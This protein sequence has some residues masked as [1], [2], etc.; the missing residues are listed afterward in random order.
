MWTNVL[1][2]I[3]IHSTLGHLWLYFK[4]LKKEMRNP[5]VFLNSLSNIIQIEYCHNPQSFIATMIYSLWYM[6]KDL[7]LKHIMFEWNKYKSILHQF[8]KTPAHLEQRCKD[9]GE[10]AT[11]HRAEHDSHSYC[12][13]PQ[14]RIPA[15][16]GSEPTTLLHLT[17]GMPYHLRVLQTVDS[18]K[19]WE[20]GVWGFWGWFVK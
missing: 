20:R 10:S 2:M 18:F 15:P 19:S 12:L 13:H 5:T 7:N 17:C 6:D 11:L 4:V 14:G 16:W 8:F 9:W 3:N 1:L